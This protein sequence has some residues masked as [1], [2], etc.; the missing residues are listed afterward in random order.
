MPRGAVRGIPGIVRYVGN[1][2][3]AEIAQCAQR[4]G[5][6]RGMANGDEQARWPGGKIATQT[7]REG[8]ETVGTPAGPIPQERAWQPWPCVRKR[9]VDELAGQAKSAAR[10]REASRDMGVADRPDDDEVTPR[11]AAWPLPAR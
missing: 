6:D 4:V 3:Y 10:M 1:A 7:V 5:G 2:A 8:A 9:G 11:H